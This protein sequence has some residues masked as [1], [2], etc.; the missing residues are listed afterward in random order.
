MTLLAV[1]GVVAGYGTSQV[2]FGI[3]LAI[4]EGEIATL[5][6]RN[7][8]GKTTLL[9]TIFSVLPAR[10]GAIEFNGQRID[11][12]PAGAIARLGLAW[13]PEGRQAFPNRTVHEH[14][15]AFAASRS[16]SVQ[17]RTPERI[18]AL[19]AQLRGRV[20]WQGSSARLAADE[21]LWHR[22]PG[23]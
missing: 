19:F 8:I 22:Y 15:V 10:A 17:R 21:A 20:V 7:G 11:G 13:V 16:D 6:V 12:R 9:P 4:A 18:Y 2:L 14:L 5:L 3:D 1:R 23:V